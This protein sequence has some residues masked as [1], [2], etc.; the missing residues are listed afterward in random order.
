MRE[1]DGR[2]LSN[3]ELLA[4]WELGEDKHDADKALLMLAM[5][6]LDMPWEDL[7]RLPLGSRDGLLIQLRTRL[8]GGHLPV[9]TQCPACH[10]RLEFETSADELLSAC[11]P[12]RVTP[13]GP[14]AVVEVEAAGCLMRARPVDSRDLVHLQP[15]M[16]RADG[17]RTLLRRVVLEARRGADPIDPGDLPP[18]AVSALAEKLAEADPAADFDFAL[19]CP[20]CGH[21]WIATFDITAYLWRELTAMAH[22]MLEDVHALAAAYGWSERDILAMSPTR[23]S[24]YLAR[25]AP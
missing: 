20:A 2:S 5:A 25:I 23:R 1:P 12:I 22:V 21:A 3:Q 13:P 4:V 18:D 6:H 17:R 9:G 10:E 14:D 8:L 15:G 16:S 7:V 24:Y 11:P 19:D